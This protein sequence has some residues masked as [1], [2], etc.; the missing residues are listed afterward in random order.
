MC[1]ASLARPLGVRDPTYTCNRGETS[2]ST[3]ILGY[4][5]RVCRASGAPSTWAQHHSA[6]G[7]CRGCVCDVEVTCKKANGISSTAV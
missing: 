3:A 1:Q 4:F 6:V 2:P 5:H 7:K